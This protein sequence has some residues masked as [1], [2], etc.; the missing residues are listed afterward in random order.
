[1]GDDKENTQRL[2][3]E[4]L[5]LITDVTQYVGITKLLWSTDEHG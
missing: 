3:Q 1:M 2:L 4:A 5:G